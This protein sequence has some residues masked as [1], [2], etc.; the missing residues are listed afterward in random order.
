MTRWIGLACALIVLTGAGTFLYQAIPDSVPEPTMEL[1]RRIEGPLPKLEL[2]GAKVHEF[3]TLAMNVKGS[4]TWQFKNV[5]QGPLEVWLEQTSCS[6]TVAQLKTKEGEPKKT[7]TIAP[8][9]SVPL[10]VTWEGRKWAPRFGQTASVGTNDPDNE[11]VNLT[12][13]GKIVAPVEVEPSESVTFPEFS[14]EESHRQTVV[15]VSPDRPDLKLTKLVSSKP[16]IIAAE[17]KPMT[18]EELQRRKV[19]SGYEVTIEIKPGLSPGGFSEELMV[20]TDHPN[21]PSLKLAIVGRTYG[22]I[23]VVPSGLVMPSVASRQGA[24]QD[25]K[26]IVR[27]AD[28][29]RFEVA[30]K[31]EKIQVAIAREEKAG[32]EGLYRIT[33]TVPPGTSPGV[34]N[35]PIVLKTD[36]PKIH[37]VKI[38]VQIYISSRS[39]AG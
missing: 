29:P 23:S 25:L 22:P 31:P 5:G 27:G 10:E 28:R 36:H 20:E 15:I 34:L 12:I 21:R 33:V 7:V 8:G 14:A 9:D 19:K 32:A 1:H 13:L 24:S 11:T 37:E 26:L 17:A 30:S 18:P 2:I 38:P 16:G 6:C 3:G 39:D 35:V 4:H